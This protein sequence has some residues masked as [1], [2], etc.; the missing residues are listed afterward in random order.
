M[1]KD[2]TKNVSIAVQP[3]KIANVRKFQKELELAT[4]SE[5]SI[6]GAVHLACSICSKILNGEKPTKADILK[7]AQ[8]LTNG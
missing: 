2:K 4:I 1:T 8:V 6:G 5:I 7:G 3:D